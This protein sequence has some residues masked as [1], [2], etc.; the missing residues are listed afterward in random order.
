MKK[1]TFFVVASAALLVTGCTTVEGDWQ[2]R[3]KLSNGKRNTMFLGSDST[4]ELKMYVA[5]DGNGLT[6]MKFEGDWEVDA[7]GNYDVYL[8]KCTTGCVEA[9]AQGFKMECGH[10]TTYEYLD[11]EAKSPFRDYGFF[12]FEPYVE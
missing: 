1:S 10:D 9:T 5:I 8:D 12:E 2:S 4:A 7:D 11:C 6:K 3:D